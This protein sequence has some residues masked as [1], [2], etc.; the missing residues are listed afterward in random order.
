MA[1]DGG[2]S[3]WIASAIVVRLRWRVRAMSLWLAP[4]A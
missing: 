2:I 3:E 4:D 1:G